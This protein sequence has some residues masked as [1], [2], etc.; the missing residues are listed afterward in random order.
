VGL[1]VDTT[2]LKIPHSQDIEFQLSTWNEH[3]HINALQPL[4]V[5]MPN[6]KVVYNSKTHF[7]GRMKEADIWSECGIVKEL[8]MPNDGKQYTFLKNNNYSQ[9]SFHPRCD[10]IMGDMA[11]ADIELPQGMRVEVKPSLTEVQYSSQELQKVQKLEAFRAVVENGMARLRHWKS[12]S[13]LEMDTLPY[14]N[15]IL[16]SVVGLSNTLCPLRKK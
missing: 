2:L 14:S 16:Q 9:Q 13:H 1:I 15:E 4:I 8:L 3:Y 11:F 10:F 12:L 5:M 7:G 6:G